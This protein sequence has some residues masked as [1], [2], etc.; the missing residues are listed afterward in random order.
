MGTGLSDL[1]SLARKETPFLD[2]VA[3]ELREILRKTGLDRTLAIGALVLNRFFDGSV[4]AWKDRRNHKNNSVRRLASRPTCPLSRSSLNRA[5]GIYAVTCTLPFVTNCNRVDA[6]HIGV[7]LPLAVSDQ[8]LWLRRAHAE[9]WSVRELRDAIRQHRRDQGE[10]RGRPHLAP[11]KRA[12]SA[13]R[14]ALGRLEGALSELKVSGLDFSAQTELLELAERLS[15]LQ[16]EFHGLQI[17]SAHEARVRRGVPSELT[18]RQEP[19]VRV[20]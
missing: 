8:E 10:R 14:S 9:C 16:A 15:L 6:S 11:T 1:S 2:E 5:I 4:A 12:L 18:V 17:R 13:T 19:G 3:V 7:V 20:A